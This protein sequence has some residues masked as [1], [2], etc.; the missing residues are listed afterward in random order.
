MAIKKYFWLLIKMSLV[1]LL[2]IGC[3]S[4]REKGK[5]SEPTEEPVEKIETVKEPPAEVVAKPEFLVRESPKLG[6]I[7]GG[8][9]ALSFAHIGLLQELENQKI[10]VHAIAGVEWGALV[11]GTFA[12]TKKAHA[13]EWQLLKMPVK[14][15]DT[16]SFFSRGQQAVSIKEFSGF[17]S[18]VF[19]TTQFSDLAVPFA[20]P[21]ANVDAE[22]PQMQTKGSLRSAMFACWPYPPHFAVE[23]VAADPSGIEPMANFLRQQGAEL[24]VYVDVDDNKLMSDKDRKSKPQAAL[25]WTQNKSVVSLLQKPIVDEVIHIPLAGQSMSSYQNLRAI[26]RTGQVKSKSVVKGL[27][28]KYAY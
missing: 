18:D 13:I 17:L 19:K 25:L 8:G 28:K 4:F 15:F 20:C 2:F 1:G 16:S 11:A 12:I 23:T 9:G 27:A 21:F 3:E 5:T 26:V 7:L 24:I 10:P 22:K 14:K 6:I